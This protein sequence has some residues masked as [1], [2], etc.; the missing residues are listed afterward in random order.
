MHYHVPQRKRIGDGVQGWSDELELAG[1]WMV[2]CSHIHQGLGVKS[3]RAS[4]RSGC[5]AFAMRS[6][7]IQT[8]LQLRLSNRICG[9]LGNLR[10]LLSRI[11]D[12][13]TIV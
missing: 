12:E 3:A 9:V 7:A 6:T 1:I 13:R 5:H 10:V 8:G 11:R 2:V 4:W